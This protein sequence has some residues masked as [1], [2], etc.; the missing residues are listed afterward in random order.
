[1]AP[2]G[3]LTAV[4]SAIRVC[5][6]PSMRAFIGRAQESPGTAE[7]ELL[8]CTSE[9]TAELFNEGGIARVFG[10]PRILELMVKASETAPGKLIVGLFSD[11]SK[12]FWK[13]TTHSSVDM[14]TQNELKSRD[15]PPN[16]SLNVGITQLPIVVTYAAAV[17]G[18]VLQIGMLVFAA[19]TV[20][21]FP[22]A[23]PGTDGGPVE[24]YAFPMTFSGTVL[25][26]VG[27]FLCAFIIER[28]TD[29]IHYEQKEKN[30]EKRCKMYWVQ[31]GGQS[32]GD[33]VFGSFIGYSD[34]RH[35]IRSTKT[36]QKGRDILFLWIAV[37]TSTVGF[38]IQFIGLRAMHASVIL[39]QIGATMLM[40]IVRAMLRTQRLDGMKN[41]IGTSNGGQ[42][43]YAFSQ[44]PKV[45]HGHELDLLALHLF[46]VDTIIIGV[47][48]TKA[49]LH[50]PTNEV[51]PSSINPYSYRAFFPARALSISSYEVGNSL[52]TREHLARIT[53]SKTGLSWKDLEVRT[54]ATQLAAAI[55]NSMEIISSLQGAHYSPG[56]VFVW[57]I[58]A[59]TTAISNLPGPSILSSLET[60]PIQ[61]LLEFRT[62]GMPASD[63]ITLS[64]EKGEGVSWRTNVAQLES[65]IGLWALS[66]IIFDIREMS[67]TL[68]PTNYRLISNTDPDRTSVWYNVWIQRRSTAST[69]SMP[70]AMLYLQSPYPVDKHL[71]GRLVP[72]R[73]D[74]YNHLSEAAR[75]CYVKTENSTVEMCAQDMF[76][77]FL[78]YALQDVPDIAGKTETRDHAGRNSIAMVLQ[79]STVDNLADRFESSGLGSREDAYMCIFPVLKHLNKMPKVDEVFDAAVERSEGFRKQGK[80]SSAEDLLRWL[81]ENPTIVDNRRVSEALAE[82]YYSAMLD[83][84]AQ[85]TELGFTGICRMLM[86]KDHSDPEVVSKIREYGWMG[87]RIAEE[88]GLDHQKAKL[89]LSGVKDDL[90]PGYQSGLSM[91]EWAKRDSL[92][93][94]RYLVRKKDADIN[95]QDSNGLTPLAWSLKNKNSEMAKLL[96]RYDADRF[97]RDNEERTAASHA[98]E[99]NVLDVLNIILQQNTTDLAGNDVHGMTPLMYA[100]K[101][102]NIGC[103]QALLGE[104]YLGIDRRNHTGDS[105]LHLAAE[106]GHTN[107]VELLL[108]KGA[109]GSA[110]NSNGQTVLHIAADRGFDGIATLLL[111]YAQLDLEQ[112]DSSGKTPLDW[113]S[114]QGRTS[115]V[116]LLLAQN[117]LP[118]ESPWTPS[119]DSR[120]AIRYAARGG[121]LD[122]LRLLFDSRERANADKDASSWLSNKSIALQEAIKGLHEDCVRYIIDPESEKLLE[123]T[124]DKTILQLAA[125]TENLN[126]VRLVL[127]TSYSASKSDKTRALHTAAGKGNLEIIEYLLRHGAHI[128][129]EGR[130]GGTILQ[131]SSRRGDE[132][133]VELL[134]Q[135]GASVNNRTDKQETA[136]HFAAQNKR[137]QIVRL[138]IKHGAEVNRITYYGKTALWIAASVGSDESI[139]ALIDAGA[140]PNPMIAS[141]ETALFV[142]ASKGREQAVRIL[143]E[144][145][146]R[147]SVNHPS[148]IDQMTPIFAAIKNR[149]QHATIVK[150][151]LDAGAEVNIKDMNGRT[152]LFEA[153]RR[154]HHDIIKLLISAGINVDSQDSQQRTALF[155]TIDG[156]R[157]DAA[158]LLLDAG[159]NVNIKN[160]LGFTPLF[161]CLRPGQKFI[162]MARLFLDHKADLDVVDNFGEDALH[163]ADAKGLKEMTQMLREEK[164]RRMGFMS[165]HSGL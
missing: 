107:I 6:T 89:L 10:E 80:W 123:R 41:L 137:P 4:V 69:T 14:F 49:I 143:L 81:Y 76:M 136:L 157:E 74:N 7:I 90:V 82:F 66:A 64:V 106:G 55:E 141:G 135:W 149:V 104:K 65:L 18:I 85:T 163:L 94:I 70:N 161:E 56:D 150:L 113:A 100:A 36:E 77:F 144:N 97:L 103:V 98:A 109:D 60:D 23:F 129:G 12:P 61:S 22:S 67:E 146:A 30:P 46:K 91:A 62:L 152:P 131:I 3:L 38:I 35:Y 73:P 156:F 50:A 122:I 147:D 15:H 139:K 40:A 2:L 92:V 102:G 9:T 5:G 108:A 86:D 83:L 31:P 117:A 124:L 132:K 32:I 16:L 153:A 110:G 84:D 112:Q 158:R 34:N 43:T 75:L 13:E 130:D 72:L 52:E 54:A 119:D 96:L 155:S 111:K 128:D 133:I 87:L 29:E 24:A 28:S 45:L 120:S 44:N 160:I 21:T 151:L 121:H 79:N 162:N 101:R 138:L 19:L 116:N 63:T 148:V 58:T 47:G 25:V 140:D 154:G 145:G 95:T 105:A 33:Q 27:M 88:R 118:F 134:L 159:A 68:N 125:R 11:V 51:K 1:M 164:E 48:D 20:F 8:S 42:R 78:L 126:M 71:F 59:N 93:M 142:A 53:N 115:I 57:S 127:E 165:H 17:F 114:E 99:N 39:Y 26:C 37:I